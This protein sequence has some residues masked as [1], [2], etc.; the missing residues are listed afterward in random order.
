M[1]KK[2]RRMPKGDIKSRRRV[3]IENVRPEV[4]GG[5][6]AVKRVAGDLVTVEADIFTD[7]HDE[8]IARLHHRRDDA[9]D[10]QTSAM[11]LGYD[12]RWHASFE[13]PDV[14]GYTYRIEAWPDRFGTWL[15]D[16]KKRIEAGQDV[17]VELATG[18]DLLR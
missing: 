16:L 3:V 13:V 1:A 18:A 5:R 11:T 4:D 12:D 9:G 6:F 17:R 15:R 8:M 10:W 2:G 14:G 7:G